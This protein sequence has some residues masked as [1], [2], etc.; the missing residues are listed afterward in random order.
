[1]GENVTARGKP[2]TAW[3]ETCLTDEGESADNTGKT[4]T[5]R[6][7]VLTA[8][9]RTFE[10]ARGKPH[11]AR[12]IIRSSLHAQMPQ[13]SAEVKL[14]VL[15]HKKPS[16]R[17]FYHLS[18]LFVFFGFGCGGGITPG[19]SSSAIAVPSMSVKLNPKI[20]AAVG[21][22]STIRA[23]VIRAPTRALAP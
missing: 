6:G 23:R 13:S 3:G 7:K 16:K 10:P 14:L 20:A 4:N 19:L 1:M 5:A 17:N 8:Q 18:L 12:G 22:M 9:A 2:Q 15:R 11:T 21:A